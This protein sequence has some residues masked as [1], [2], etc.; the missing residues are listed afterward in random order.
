MRL[1]TLLLAPLL[2]ACQ[3]P[4]G[5]FTW[6]DDVPAV[7][8]APQ[9]YRIR[10][11]DRLQVTVYKQ[12]TVSGAVVVRTDGKITLPLVGD[13]DVLNKTAPEA[14]DVVARALATTGYIDKPSVS[15]A[16]LQTREPTFSVVGEVRQAGSFALPPSTTLLD[17][18]ALAGGLTEF[19]QKD[20]VFVVR[21]RGGE[22]ARIRFDYEKLTRLDGKAMQYVLDDGDVVVVE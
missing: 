16:L 2:F 6:V 15:V 14:A 21:K 7:E 8:L 11:S 13:I 4:S 5:T 17:A 20:R 18:V 10:A 9:P 12:E 19:A 1:C 3:T 22:N